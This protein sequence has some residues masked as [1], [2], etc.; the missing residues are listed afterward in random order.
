MMV[1]GAAM[2]VSG[3]T[4]PGRANSK[5]KSVWGVPGSPRRQV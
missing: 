2:M 4:V 5:V 3:A 1:S